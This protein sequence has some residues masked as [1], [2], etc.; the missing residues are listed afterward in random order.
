MFNHVLEKFYDLGVDGL[1]RE[2]IQNSL[3][4]KLENS[5]LPVVVTIET[6]KVKPQEIPGIDEIYEH[7]RSLKGENEYTK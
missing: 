4:G 1:V 7:I 3:D 2:N 6:G 5:E